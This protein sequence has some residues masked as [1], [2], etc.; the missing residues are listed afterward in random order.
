MYKEVSR[1]VP[2]ERRAS[3]AFFDHYSFQ[4]GAC[5]FLIALIL[6]VV[7]LISVPSLGQEQYKYMK[8]VAADSTPLTQHSPV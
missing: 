5:K 2:F 1:F 7:R 6:F 4:Q 8:F 3:V